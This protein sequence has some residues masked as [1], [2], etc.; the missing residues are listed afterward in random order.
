MGCHTLAIFMHLKIGHAPGNL[1]CIRKFDQIS[2]SKS[3]ILLAIAG[4][5]QLSF[6][7]I[8]KILLLIVAIIFVFFYSGKQR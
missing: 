7:D 3:F 2:T 4:H 6:K 5:C 1:E 8:A